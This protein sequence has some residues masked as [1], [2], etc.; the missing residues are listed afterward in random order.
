MEAAEVAVVGGG[1]A[2]AALA[3]KLARSG[4][5][6]LVMDR[7]RFPRA[8]PCAESLSPEASRILH[9]MGI[10]ARI[11][12]GPV[13]HLRGIDVRA[14]NGAV[15]RGDFVADHGYRGFAE[16]GLSVRRELLD[17]MLL[18][19]ARQAGAR[20]VEE[21]RVSGLRHDTSG[22]VNGVDTTRGPVDARLVVG[23]DG[24]QSLV[25][26]RLGLARRTRGPR[27]LALVTHYAGVAGLADRGE[28]HVEPDGYVGIADVGGGNATVAL[29]VP[30]AQGR[31][32]AGDK[33]GFLEAWIAGRPHLAKRF[34][35]AV[36]VSPVTATGPF[37]SRARRAWAPGAAL[38]GDA[39]DFY[40]PFTGEGIYAALRGGE[41]LGTAANEYLRARNDAVADAAL[42]EYDARRRSEFSGKWLVERIVAAVVAHP[43][44]M[45][46]AAGGLAA[47]K[48]LADLLIGVTGDFVPA[49]AV[50]RPG[51]LWGV[52]GPR[53]LSSALPMRA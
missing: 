28:M 45:N 7:A 23:A 4:V 24:L 40:D 6:V 17:H 29:V 18:D 42:R 35:R 14:P 37:C 15:L 41:M 33:A 39:A 3:W 31:G 21:V 9:D 53:P 10:L 16:R 48:E 46:R 51:F 52:F 25:S 44:L 2:G 36:R 43:R 32:A 22:R 50:T 26:H 47:R 5:D 30:H 34:E 20:V 19:A 38:V 13:A 1:P 11:E 49:R 27:R 12:Q 8:K